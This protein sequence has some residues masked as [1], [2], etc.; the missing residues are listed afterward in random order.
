M[1]FRRSIRAQLL[2]LILVVAAPLLLLTLYTTYAGIEQERAQVHATALSLAQLTATNVEQLLSESEDILATIARRPLV[3]AMDPARCDPILTEIPALFPQF[4]GLGLINPSGQIICSTTASPES[5]LPS[6]GDRPWFQNLR[7]TRSFTVSDVQV[8]RITGRWVSVLAYP[9]E[10]EN[11]DFA[12]ALVLPIDLVRYQSGLDN[13]T[14][15]KGGNITIVDNEGTVVARSVDS[16]RWVGQNVRDTDVVQIVLNQEI[17][18]VQAVGFDGVEKIYGVTRVRATDW[19]VY[20]GIPTEVALAPAQAM[21]LQQT[22]LSLAIITLVALVA[23]YLVWQTER[24]MRGLAEVAAA[25]AAGKLDR[26]A[27]VTGPQEF[28]EVATQFNKMLD[29][30]T[31]HTAQLEYRAR[32][33]TA[34]GYMG[35][36]VTATLDLPLLFERVLEQVT[37]LLPAEGISILLLEQGELRSAAI[38][39]PIAVGLPPGERLPATSGIAGEVIQ[40][41]H[42]VW[43]PDTSKRPH[44]FQDPAR[45]KGYRVQTLLVVPL[46]L[47]GAVIGVMEAVHSQ[48]DAF[49]PEDLQ[50]LEAAASWTAIAIENARLFAEQKAARQMT[51]I[52]HTAN[53]ALTQ[54]LD[55]Q[56]I[57]DTLLD[58]LGKLVPYDS[59]SVWLRESPSRLVVRAARGYE[60]W[61]SPD[62]LQRIVFNPQTHPIL[63]NLYTAQESILLPDTAQLP[64]WQQQP[65][66]EYIRNWMGIPLLI[67]GE[68]IGVLSVDKHEAEFFTE[69]HLRS[70]ETLAILAG[71][72]I[73]NA[74][75]FE[76]VQISHR[77]LRRLAQQVVSAQE[78]ERQRIAREL[79]DEA[80]QALIALKISLDL[81]KAQMPDSMPSIRQRLA[82]AVELT[83][84]TM[85]QIRL[86]AHDLRPPVLEAFGLNLALEGLC[87]SFAQRTHLTINYQ[88]QELPPLPD[89]LGMTLY[90]AVQEGLTNIAKHAQASEATVILHYDGDGVINVAIKD[91]GQGFVAEDVLAPTIRPSGM[92]LVGMRERLEVLGGQVEVHS[93]PAQGTTLIIYA[94]LLVEEQSPAPVA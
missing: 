73:Q 65:G 39:G 50:L 68:I 38:S 53:V 22:V 64:E 94:P 92:G 5:E 21:V 26:R 89:V 61:T 83:D 45:Y 71:V 20:V 44:L 33:L 46:K 37:P 42:S 13:V 69:S 8:G 56:T 51:E 78:E 23:T 75:L 54:T 82:E 36:A 81:M 40:S 90:R 7:R 47:H 29:V 72:A 67:G 60:R 74:R 76:Q 31:Q 48:P 80:G 63:R 62:T 77:Q 28:V 2:A 27:P 52:L 93:Q 17:E 11:G 19:R 41:G 88:G 43:L 24:P 57:L 35:Q 9:V 10:G 66:T 4:V 34:L 84:Q 25:V 30:Q 14:L 85:E 87:N 58:H 6:L 18:Q 16:E 70:A 3:R 55:L 91:N 15:P 86:L 59:A 79:H 49:S 1:N 32:Q 12:G